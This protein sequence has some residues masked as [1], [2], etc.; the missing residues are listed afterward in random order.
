[1]TWEVLA[2]SLLPPNSATIS[3]TCLGLPGVDSSLKVRVGWAYQ[4]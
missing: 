2:A 3:G 1:M 4:L